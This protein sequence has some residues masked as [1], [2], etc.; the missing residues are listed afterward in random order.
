MHADS[1]NALSNIFRVEENSY[2][3]AVHD[4]SE[5]IPK[6]IENPLLQLNIFFNL[7][8]LGRRFYK[9]LDIT[10]AKTKSVSFINLEFHLGVK[11]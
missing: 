9:A 10:H 7:S 11:M 4:I 6:R 5:I 1:D 8:P 3:Q 2:L